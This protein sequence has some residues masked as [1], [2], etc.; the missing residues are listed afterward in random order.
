MTQAKSALPSRIVF[1]DGVC[2]F[3]DGAV[4]WVRDR[5]P[6][7]AFHF[8]P[9]QG[10]TAAQVRAGYPDEFPA[11][12]DTIVYLETDSTHT[13]IFTRAEAIFELCAHLSGRWSWL[14][15]LRVLPRWLTEPAYRAFAA[16]RYRIFGRI[17]AC[18]LPSEEDQARMLR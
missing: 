15:A 18:E 11:D 14:A 7:G 8:A 10:E 2:S 17:D 5:D 13:R 12:L 9:L 3:C 6:S 1:F 16:N 4:R